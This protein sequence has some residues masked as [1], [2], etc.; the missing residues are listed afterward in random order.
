MKNM[1]KSYYI[2]FNFVGLS[3]VIYI[4]VNIFYNII[5]SQLKQSTT[6]ETVI[7]QIPDIESIKKYPLSDFNVILFRNVF[8]T[9][10]KSSEEIKMKK[11]EPLEPTSLRIALLGTA[12]GDKKNTY[13]IIEE[14]GKRK[15]ALYRVGDSVKGAII[16]TILKGKVILRMMDKDEI[17][18]MKKGSFSG[19]EEEHN[20]PEP[21]IDKG[22]HIAVNYSELQDSLKDL[23]KLM[24]QARIFPYFK[25]GEADGLIITRIKRNSFF[26]K[27]GL[28]NGDIV[29]GIDGKSI[30][31]PDDVLGLYGKLRAGSQISLQIR[32]NDS[33]KTINYKFK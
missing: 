30:N 23:N 28:R 32:R 5:S 10:D 8:D 12:I 6:R 20:T 4:G 14:T 24:S 22:S 33:S 19:P 25:D 9:V 2:L 27:L 18:T 15:Q 17:L 11:I 26:S 3:M 31:S 16:K 29:Q 13:A 1:S 7:R 21:I